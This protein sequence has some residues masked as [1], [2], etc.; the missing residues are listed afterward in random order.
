MF[1]SKVQATV[2]N[3]FLLGFAIR[4]RNS[5]VD[6]KASG[7]FPKVSG[8]REI[9]FLEISYFLKKILSVFQSILNDYI[10]IP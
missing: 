9:E 5:V 3:R 2:L 6:R 7:N 4:S 1:V 8:N 10:N